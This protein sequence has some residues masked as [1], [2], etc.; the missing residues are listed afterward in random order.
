LDHTTTMAQ[1]SPI[2]HFQIHVDDMRPADV[3]VEQGWREMDIRFLVSRHSGGSRQV[4]W[5]RTV[6]P[7]GGA[8]ERHYHPNAEEVLYVIRGRGAAGTE[9]TEHEVTPGT[10]HYIPAGVTHWLRNASDTEDLEIV[11][12]YAPAASLEEAGYVFVS[13]ITEE[14]RQVT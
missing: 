13:E 10:A 5:W 11:G 8:H 12:C 6:F 4:C 1:Q 7:P 2:E 3:R 14:Y 9:E